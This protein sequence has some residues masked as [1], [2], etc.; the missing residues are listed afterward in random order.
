MIVKDYYYSNKEFKLSEIQKGV[1]KTQNI[2]N[3]INV[4]YDSNNYISHQNCKK[5]LKDILYSYFQK[6]NLNYKLSIIQKYSNGKNIIDYGCGNGL[7]LRYMKNNG[8]FVQGYELNETA[9]KKA[10]N[11]INQKLKNSI[12]EF[13]KTD[14]VTLWHVL[15]HL[16]NPLKVLNQLQKKLNSDGII[17]IA[18][19]NYKSFDA[20]YY[21]CFWSAYDV[22]RHIYHYSKE[23]FINYFSR[24]FKIIGTA[25]LLFDSYYV[26]LLSENYKKSSFRFLNAIKI[27]FQSNWKAKKTANYSSIIYIL[28]KSY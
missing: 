21:K 8:Y 16:K 20:E 7:F 9:K 12:H 6:Y 2:P 14:I 24:Y 22:P 19:P 5:N 26:S 10:E 18:V 25:P 13:D 3:N 11:K 17:F 27:G 4:Y 23:G 1:L 15:E 28:K